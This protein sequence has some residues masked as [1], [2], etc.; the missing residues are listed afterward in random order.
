M[1]TRSCRYRRTEAGAAVPALPE[2]PH[3]VCGPGAET[4]ELRYRVPEDRECGNGKER[5]NPPG[6]KTGLMRRQ[7]K[8]ILDS[9]HFSTVRVIM[10]TFLVVILIGTVLLMLPVST[11]AGEWCPFLTALF[12][13]T[14]SVC[15]TGLV[16]VDTC[17]YWSMFG[18]VIILL[19]IQVGGLSVVILWAGV[20]M[21]LH[22]RF[23]LRFRML[24]RDYYNL[25]NLRG[26]SKFMKNVL[27]GTLIAEVA[28]ALLYSMVFVPQYGF[29]KG[30]WFSVFTSV[31][32]F[33]NAGIDILGPDSLIPYRS[34]LP[35]NL[36]TMLLIVL[37]GLGFYVW[38]DLIRVY[39][40]CRETKAGFRTFFGRL[41]EHTRLVLSV[42]LVLIISGALIVYIGECSNPA[43]LG[44]MNFGEKALASLFQ[45]VTF[46]TAGFSTVPQQDLTPFTCIAGLFYMLIGGSPTG[47]AGGIKTVTA[48]ILFLNAA[49]YI[50]QENETVVYGRTVPHRM[51]SRAIAIMTVFLGMTVL[52]IELL[53]LTNDVPALSAVFEIFSATGTVGL[54]RALTASLNTAGRWIVIVAMYLGR[55]APISM[56]LFFATGSK[57]RK[58]LQYP[59]GKFLLG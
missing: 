11:A 54:S 42:T 3:F 59:E 30:L 41:H 56:V 55:I 17:S 7:R 26:I 6:G 22:K 45:S 35:V 57:S 27:K 19:L 33:C 24:I 13:A 8:R 4:P 12:T 49:S 32:A 51:I 36:I 23:S 9:A 25:E 31:S 46:R 44:G 53:L 50:R 38:F 39:R 43:T 20:M 40:E 15:V 21:L 29:L 1:S 34:N 14:T 18:K 48:A 2:G 52:F 28:G 58:T 16:V 10:L 37:G 47:T 5:R